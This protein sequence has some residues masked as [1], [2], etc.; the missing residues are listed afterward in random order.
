[1]RRTLSIFALLVLACLLLGGWQQGILGPILMGAPVSGAPTHT[2]VQNSVYNQTNGH[3]VSSAYGSNVTSGNLLIAMADGSAAGGDLTITDTAGFTWTKI[4]SAADA[5]GCFFNSNSGYLCAWYAVAGSTHSETVTVTNV[6]TGN[7]IAL[8]VQEWH[9]SS[10]SPNL[11][12]ETVQAAFSGTSF[13]SGASASATGASELI[14]GW[15]SDSA[16]ETATAVSGTID[17]IDAASTSPAFLHFGY[18]LAG[19]SGAQTATFAISSG[20]G[21]YNAAVAAF[22]P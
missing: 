11:D 9:W 1:M 19:P 16:N 3:S 15:S 13:T 20:G 10:S 6:T 4:N 14:L 5:N 2:R 12:V 7:N 21:F 18:K 17:T 8:A 22:K